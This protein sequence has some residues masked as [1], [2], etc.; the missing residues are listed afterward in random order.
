MS[1]TIAVDSPSRSLTSAQLTTPLLTLNHQ[2]LVDSGVDESF[3]Y[4]RLAKRLCLER[5]ALASSAHPLLPL[6]RA[7]SSWTRKT[8]HFA[9]ASTTMG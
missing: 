8:R 7:S 1:Q 4:W 2:V 5:E 9:F 3:M 6:E